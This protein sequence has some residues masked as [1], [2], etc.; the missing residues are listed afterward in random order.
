MSQL[1]LLTGNFFILIICLVGVQCCYFRQRWKW[2]WLMLVCVLMSATC[3][4]IVVY[5]WLSP[6]PE[7]ELPIVVRSPTT[8]L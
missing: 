4:G 3:I 7:R 6:A 8:P 2:F 1:L 5:Q